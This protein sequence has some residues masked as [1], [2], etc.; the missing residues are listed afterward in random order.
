M[1]QRQSLVRDLTT[2]SVTRTLLAFS[3]PLMLSNL[4]QIVYN[5]VD[6]IVV[7]RYVGSS[8]LS[9]VACGGDL[10]HVAMGL[11]MGFSSAGQIIISQQVGR[12]DMNGMKKTIGTLFSFIALISLFVTVFGLL[13]TDWML[14]AMHVPAEAYAQARDYTLVC[15]G[16]MFFIFGYN[17]VSAILRGM[18]D[19]RRPLVFIAIAA[20]TNLILDLI[21]V[22]GFGWGPLGAAVATVI[23]QAMSFVISLIYLYRKREAFHFDFAPKSFKPDRHT[24]WLLTRLGV[25]MALQHGAIMFSR[26]FVNSYINAYGLIASAVNGMGG[27][28]SQCALVV[29][30]ALSAAGTSMI[31]QS[32]GAGKQDRIRKAVYVILFFGLAYS[33]LLALILILFPDLVFGLFNTDPE[34]LTMAHSYIIIAVFSFN[35]FAVRGPMMALINGLGCSELSLAVGLLDGIIARIGIAVFLGVTLGLGIKGFWWGDIIAGHIPFLI[36]GIYFWT[37][38]WKRRR[39]LIVRRSEAKEA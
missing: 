12:G 1:N 28:I 31:G 4:L 34:V 29:S 35:G 20:F 37:G 30:N 16:G 17:T 18:G 2:G 7:G 33:W 32:F 11:C 36:G 39:P 21:F 22:A 23:G 19:S 8:G 25:P 10:M 27:K 38:L 9:A 6:M 24:L 13:G 26:L 3:W 5:M 14:T 15:M